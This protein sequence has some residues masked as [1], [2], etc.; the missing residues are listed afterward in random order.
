MLNKARMVAAGLLLAAQTLFWGA[1]AAGQPEAAPLAD[2]FPFCAWWFETTATSLNVAF[3]DT[4]AAYWTT[5]LLA[6]PDLQSVTVSGQYL[7]ARYFSLNAYNNGG[8][9]Y[10]C[11]AAQ[12]P[13]ALADYLIVPDSGSQ[14]PFQASAPP[15]G[16]YTVTLARA[17]TGPLAP[18]T[19]PLYSYP[20]CQP[21]PSQGLL[22]STLGFLILR[23]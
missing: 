21:A 18:N 5:P 19:L 16:H 4:S 6:A 22:P 12:T 10:A 11:G 23:A 1:P 20:G 14:N 7:D 8:A 15:G 3:P 17:G 9:S 13:S 2:L